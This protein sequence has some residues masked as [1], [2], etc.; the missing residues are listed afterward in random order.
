MLSA[1]LMFISYELPHPPCYRHVRVHERCQRSEVLV[2]SLQVIRSVSAM[3]DEQ[4]QGC[5]RAGA[6][7]EA[8]YC[9]PTSFKWSNAKYTRQSSMARMASALNPLN[10]KLLQIFKN[11]ARTSKRTPHFTITKIN[12]LML[13]IRK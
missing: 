7:Q 13:F 11:S 9:P 6:V 5:S 1:E 8:Q 3:I 4:G 2:E 10:P 12:W